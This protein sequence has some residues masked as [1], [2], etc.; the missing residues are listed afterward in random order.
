MG[1]LLRDL[2]YALRTLARTPGFT[3]G[4]V[5]T[6]ALGMGVNAAMFGVVDT[7]FLKPPAGVAQPDRVVRIYVRRKFGNDINTGGIGKYP[8]FVD[9]R[10]SGVFDRTAA[11]TQRDLSLGRGAQA[12]QIHVGAVSHDY[13]PLLGVSPARGRFFTAAEDTPA[14]ERVAVLSY[15]FWQRRFAGDTAV[16][17]RALQIGKGTYTVIGIGPRSFSGIELAPVDLWLPIEVSAGEI[18]NTEALTSRSWWWMEAI[19]RLKPGMRDD[20]AAALATLTLQRGER[21]AKGQDT[22]ATVVLGPIEAARSPELSDTSRVSMWIG[23]VSLLVLLIACANVAN[24]LLARGAGRRRE[25]AVRAGLGAGRGGLASL[26]L[27]ESLVLAS[28]GGAA[29]LLLAAWGGALV[30]SLLIPDLPAGTSLVD[31]RVLVF[32]ALAVLVTTLLTGM[33][34][35]ISSSSTDLAEALKSGNHTTYKGARVR[36]ALVIAQVALTLVLLV[37]AGLF[38]RS[39]RN[40]ESLDLGFDAPKVLEVSVNLDAAGVSPSE[41]NSTYLSLLDR[42]RQLP[43]VEHAAASMGTPFNWGYK[44]GFHAQDVD[45]AT[46]HWRGGAYFTGVTP[47]YFGTMGTRL[48]AGRDFTDA[49]VSGAQQV[50]V[51]EASMASHFWPGR[52]ALG[53]C[54][55]LGADTVTTCTQI[56]GIV[57]DQKRGSVT[58]S[59]VSF[60]QPIAQVKNLHISALMVRARTKGTDIA[61]AIRREVQAR[62]N[63]PFASVQTL[64]QQIS[65]QLRSWR[66]GAEAF[67]AFGILA[68]IISATGIFA[69]IAYSV[70]QRTQE[71]G[72]RM[73]LGAET[74]RVARMILAQGLRATI[75][76]VVVGAAGAYAMAR[77]LK[78][79]L[80]GVGPADPLVF[81]GVA[82]VLVVVAAAAAWFP[83]RRAAKIDPMVALRYE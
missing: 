13:F 68:L 57:A 26:L 39:L 62:G 29:A 10:G 54:L 8:A 17:G 41:V 1:K 61:D 65:P 45:T 38:V 18:A 74:R 21:G 66:L 27:S 77:A 36:A 11:A 24:L 60:Y 7:L 19:A 40:V 59:S 48:A 14:G 5:L 76:G 25:L 73:A 37:G 50:A 58:D 78:S 23:G 63:L 4:I 70:S 9:L 81:V 16:L 35:A 49:D 53:K 28:L 82:S 34:P 56:V 6:L 71:I 22:L 3:F 52:S 20:Q 12:E 15:G 2:R 67:S 30:R 55:Y 33:L 79:L 80:Y 47:G 44:F 51:I 72:I 31:G 64:E 43:G 75:A 42:V 69:V 46:V 83:A 32:T